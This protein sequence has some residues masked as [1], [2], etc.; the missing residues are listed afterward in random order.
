MLLTWK[1]YTSYYCWRSFGSAAAI[2]ASRRL[3][4][5]GADADWVDEIGK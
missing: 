2:Q 4:E 1:Q 3:I 5:M